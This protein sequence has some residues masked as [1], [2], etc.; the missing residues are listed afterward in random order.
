MIVLKQIFHEVGP[1]I[2]SWR[3]VVHDIKKVEK[4][5]PKSS[6]VEKQSVSNCRRNGVN[7]ATSVMGTTLDKSRI[8]ANKHLT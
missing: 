6:K 1:E 7:L 5:C 4:H 2:K 8:T 3:K